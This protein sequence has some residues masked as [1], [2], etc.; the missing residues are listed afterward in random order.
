[1]VA[2]GVL[3]GQEA[4]ALTRGTLIGVFGLCG[5]LGIMSLTYA[6]GQVY[7]SIGRQAPF[8]MMGLVNFAVCG[9]ALWVRHRST[10][11][12]PPAARRA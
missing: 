5:S 6:G 9:V 10:A 11:R 7:D 3:I 2:A 1:V 12:L 4:P 8:V